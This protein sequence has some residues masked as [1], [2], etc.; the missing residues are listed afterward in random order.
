MLEHRG[1]S[2]RTNR[3]AGLLVAADA[4][5]LA[6]ARGTSRTLIALA[7][8]KGEGHRLARFN[9]EQLEQLDKCSSNAEQRLPQQLVMAY[10]HLLL[11][12]ET[13]EG[14]A[15]LH[16]IDLGPAGATTTIT[17]R[18]FEY[19]RSS[20]RLIETTLAP[21][22]LLGLVPDGAEAI[23]LGN[24]LGYFYRPPRLPRL[25][26]PDVLRRA[27][28]DGVTKGLLGLASGAAWNA[29]D[30]VVRFA[31]AQDPSEIEFQA[32]T[33]L[34]RAGAARALRADEREP[35]QPRPCRPPSL[36]PSI[37][38]MHRRAGR[39]R[40]RCLRPLHCR[41]SPSGSATCLLPKHG[42]S[43]RVAVIPLAAVSPDLELDMVIRADGEMAGMPKETLN[44]MVLEGLCQLGL[45]D[46]DCS[47]PDVD[48]S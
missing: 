21:A 13:D 37:G 8:L 6:K 28:A 7:D 36:S 26:G 43:S 19:L 12:G 20:D 31:E 14:G 18:V 24:L 30:A 25:A 9:A 33:W 17:D 4:P 38:P 10:R 34:V 29:P 42:T 23:E 39:S 1:N 11:L 16:H 32:G 22:A 2:W 5:A 15:H 27:L 40:R 46:V 45:T 47:S 48:N 3:N 44:L 41:P 35:T